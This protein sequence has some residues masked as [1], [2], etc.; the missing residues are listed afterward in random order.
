VIP[1]PALAIAGKSTIPPSLSSAPLRIVR[2]GESYLALHVLDVNSRFVSIRRSSSFKTHLKK[3]GLD[4]S[5][6]LEFSS[7]DHSPVEVWQSTEPEGIKEGQVFNPNGPSC[8][9]EIRLPVPESGLPEL[10]DP[11]QLLSHPLYPCKFITLLSPSAYL[12]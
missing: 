9:Q 7:R 5:I 12:V 4:P 3:H 11:D 8:S 1:H 6:Y 2:Q 10:W